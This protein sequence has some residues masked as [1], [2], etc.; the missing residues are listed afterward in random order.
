MTTK[1]PTVFFPDFFVPEE[2]FSP[3]IIRFLDTGAIIVTDPEISHNQRANS[4]VIF[5]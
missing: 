5:I 3:L 4:H 1:V 2:L